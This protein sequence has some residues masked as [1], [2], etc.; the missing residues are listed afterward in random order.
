MRRA[1]GVVVA[2][3][4]LTA[5][6]S[7][8]ASSAEITVFAAASLTNVFPQI[9]GAQRY[10]FAGSNTLAAQIEQGAPADVFASADMVLPR[11]LYDERPL[12]EARR[13]HAERTGDRRSTIEPGKAALDLRP[14]AEGRQARRRGAGCAR[15]PLHA[16]AAQEHE[17]RREGAAERRQPRDRRPRRAREG[18]ARRGRR[19]L[20]LLDRCEG[21]PGAP[22]SDQGAGARTTRDS[23][24]HLSRRRQ[25]RQ[26]RCAGLR[27]EGVEQ[28]GPGPAARCRLSAAREEDG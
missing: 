11:K 4:A 9:D 3:V 2:L 12:L 23:V 7:Q 17:A 14:R 1:L 24:R 8:A 6:A 15:W 26:G 20:R 13:V 28:G 25:Q 21:R 19:R 22:E 27:A 16:A 10:S 18:R 5:S